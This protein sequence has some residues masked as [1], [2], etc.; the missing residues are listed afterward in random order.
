MATGL[1]SSGARKYLTC[2]NIS[3]R[4]GLDMAKPQRFFSGM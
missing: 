2:L 3:V 1:P 4:A